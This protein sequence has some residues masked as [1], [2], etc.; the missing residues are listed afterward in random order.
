MTLNA[1]LQRHIQSGHLQ[2]ARTPSG[3]R[4][5]ATAPLGR[6]GDVEYEVAVT[7]TIT[8][9]GHRKTVTSAWAGGSRVQKVPLE[10]NW[11]AVKAMREIEAGD[12]GEDALRRLLD[13]T[14]LQY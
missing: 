14:L 3:T 8:Y 2:A 6:H 9:T 5:A 7:I 13:A 11:P 4:L 10:A 1:T 12:Q